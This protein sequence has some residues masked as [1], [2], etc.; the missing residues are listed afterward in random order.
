MQLYKYFAVRISG[1]SL[2]VGIKYTRLKSRLIKS[3]FK[4]KL[5]LITFLG[6]GTTLIYIRFICYTYTI[7]P[8]TASLKFCFSYA[9]VSDG[10]L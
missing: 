1:K 9:K 2:F 10:I 6:H 4:K 3:K 8:P 5:I 7:F